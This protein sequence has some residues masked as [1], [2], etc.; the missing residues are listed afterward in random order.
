M[1]TEPGPLVDYFASGREFFDASSVLP[2]AT[3]VDR[4]TMLVRA[5]LADEPIVIHSHSAFFLA[6]A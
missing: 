2:W 3:L 6:R 4:F 5:R 1:I